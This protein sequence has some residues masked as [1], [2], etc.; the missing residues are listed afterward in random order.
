[1]SIV[2]TI[3]TQ[4]I[5]SVMSAC[6]PISGLVPNATAVFIWDLIKAA[7]HDTIVLLTALI[8]V[9]VKSEKFVPVGN[10]NGDSEPKP[11]MDS[12]WMSHPLKRNRG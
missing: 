4:I 2:F 6:K 11:I 7:N 9:I 12:R 3:A 1:V 5:I 10:Q 8:I